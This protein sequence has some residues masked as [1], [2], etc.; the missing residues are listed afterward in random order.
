MIPNYLRPHPSGKHATVLHALRGMIV[1]G[2]LSPGSRLPTRRQLESKFEAGPV[3]IQRALNY[4]AAEGFTEA[5]GRLGT[6]VTANP[7]HLCHYGLAFFSHLGQVDQ[8]RLDTAI[9]NEASAINETHD[10]QMRVYH[11]IVDQPDLGAE[12]YRLIADAQANKLAGI[13]FTA[14]PPQPLVKALATAAPQTP[15]VAIMSQP[16]VPNVTAVSLGEPFVAKALQY[17]AARGRRRIACLSI[18]SQLP[19]ILNWQKL[20]LT[21][22]PQHGMTT[23]PYWMLTMGSRESA[24]GVSAV[25]HLLFE[26]G[27]SNRPDA[28]FIADDNFVEHATAGLLAAGVRVPE[29]VDVVAHCNFPWPVPNAMPVKRLG[30]DARDVLRQCISVIDMQRRGQTPPKQV[31]VEA[32]FEEEVAAASEQHVA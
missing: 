27:R 26:P 2:R 22:I 18:C 17:L 14:K 3:T 23:E 16:D 8:R 21:L 25:V 15:C 6:F 13:I 12:H 5:R 30:Y 11:D 31:F 9:M 19:T 7:P 20:L 10:R 1:A 4:L 29:D 24:T 32:V 28:L